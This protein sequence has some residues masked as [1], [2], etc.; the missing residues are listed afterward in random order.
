MAWCGSCQQKQNVSYFWQLWK[1]ES[2]TGRFQPWETFS[3]KV[4]HFRDGFFSYS[5][6][7][8][9]Y[10]NHRGIHS[11]DVEEKCGCRGSVSVSMAEEIPMIK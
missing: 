10:K 3:G 11:F 9:I 4:L 1:D 7:A 2:K 6:E 5:L 8:L